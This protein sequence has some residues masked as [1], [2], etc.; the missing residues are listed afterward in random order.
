MKKN[1]VLFRNSLSGFNKEDV[2]KYIKETDMKH[3]AEIE[4]LGGKLS[5]IEAE[6]YELKARYDAEKRSFDTSASV[7]EE[8][9]KKNQELENQIKENAIVASARSL[10]LSNAENRINEYKAEIENLNSMLGMYSNNVA[11]ENTDEQSSGNALEE[12][13]QYL[14]S[15]N[16]EKDIIISNLNAEIERLNSRSDDVEN[17]SES[18][19]ESDSVKDNDSNVS[20]K[21]EMY[22]RISS[23]VG[24]ILINAN[25][26]ADDIIT[27]AKAR[28]EKIAEEAEKEKNKLKEAINSE[29]ESLSQKMI[30]SAS[31]TVESISG[32]INDD[33]SKYLNGINEK[34]DFLQRELNSLII[35]F[36]V[37][38]DEFGHGF[39][40]FKE[41][42][43]KNIEDS[44]E[45]FKGSVKE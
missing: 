34:I 44:I 29:A 8:L 25:R 16:E 10:D 12:K 35:K 33:A 28:A 1:G 26:S 22:D 9:R 14:I 20:Y 23:Q 17:V 24:D 21:L 4:E 39:E 13:F 19:T 36:N 6:Y 3:S 37:S 11:E 18:E 2:N 45:S 38:R 5:R 43:I 30:R 41:Q 15:Q 27:A 7:V 31:E 42:S 40:G 32:L